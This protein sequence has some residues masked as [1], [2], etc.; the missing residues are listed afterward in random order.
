[1]FYVASDKNWAFKWKLGFW[2][3]C[4][5]L[6][7]KGFSDKAGS[8]TNFFFEGGGYC[9]MKCQH[10]ED[11]HSEPIFSKWPMHD[12]T[13]SYIEK[14]FKVQNRPVDFKVREQ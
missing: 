3:T 6:I 11:L 1:M 5:L 4:I 10:L 2:E 13:K 12:I 8:D 9:T 14:R 7:F